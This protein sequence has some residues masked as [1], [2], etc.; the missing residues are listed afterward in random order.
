MRATIL[1]AAVVLLAG[2][3]SSEPAELPVLSDI[4]AILDSPSAYDGEMIRVQGAALVR[5]EASFICA[6]PETLSI[7]SSSKRSMG[8]ARSVHWGA[9]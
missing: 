5:F 8:R 2:C 1:A 9:L 6:S 7:L 3:R 4:E